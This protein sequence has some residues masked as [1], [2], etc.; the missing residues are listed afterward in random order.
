VARTRPKIEIFVLNPLEVNCYVVSC[1]E[2]RL[3]V[4][5]DPGAESQEVISYIFEQQIAPI[6]ILNTHGHLDHIAGNQFFKEK[7]SIPIFIHG[8]DA[9]LLQ[10]D[11]TTMLAP[12]FP[13]YNAIQ[14]D[15]Y[16]SDDQVLEVGNFSLRV[17]ETP[18]H[19]QGS[20]SFL[21]ENI[22]FCGD[23]LFRGSV[24]RTDFSGGDASQLII[25]ITQRLLSLPDETE[26]FPG[27]GEHTTIGYERKNNPF[28]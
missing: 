9:H 23:T 19:T 26:C 18:G 25:S 7:F 13:C 21:V 8:A 1:S 14:A 17:M 6:M 27:H 11:E 12:L 5:I 15:F 28:L 3:G 2:S 10:G 20:V 16:L 24:G 22:V 4:I